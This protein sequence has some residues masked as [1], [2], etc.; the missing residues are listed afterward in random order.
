MADVKLGDEPTRHADCCLS[1]STT[2][3]NVL[4]SIVNRRAGSDAPSAGSERLVLSVGSGSGLL[5]ALLQQKW[6]ADPRDDVSSG[7]FIEGVEVQQQSGKPSLLNK[8]L[9]EQHHSGV[10]GTWDLSPRAAEAA[11]L[12]FVYPRSPELLMRYLDEATTHT[13][14]RLGLVIW[15]GPKCDW[16]EFEGAFTGYSGWD[17]RVVPDD[18]SGLFGYEMIAV[19]EKQAEQES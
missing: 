9:P 17:T 8:Y 12:M 16:V 2:L 14:G 3:L 19:L 4:T 7:L 13:R 11:V 6:T 1:L 15:L 18:E 5:E 10:K